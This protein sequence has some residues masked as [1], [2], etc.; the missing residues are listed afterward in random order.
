[1]NF[2]QMRVEEIALILTGL[3]AIYVEANE[4]ARQKLMKQC[5]DALAA[6]GVALAA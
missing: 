4:P 1:M 2:R 6:R 5:E 3:R